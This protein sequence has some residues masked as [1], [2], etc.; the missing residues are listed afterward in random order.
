MFEGLAVPRTTNILNS[1]SQVKNCIFKG[2]MFCS[3]IFQIGFASI[4]RHRCLEMKRGE[5]GSKIQNLTI[6]IICV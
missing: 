5:K 6:P 4:P 3:D 1:S 2:K